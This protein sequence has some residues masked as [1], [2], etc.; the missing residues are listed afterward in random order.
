MRSLA[1][2]AIC[3]LGCA[4]GDYAH[5]CR[6]QPLAPGY[7]AAEVAALQRVGASMTA[8]GVF[9]CSATWSAGSPRAA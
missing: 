2:L 6:A 5:L 7:A 8:T 9:A 4:R 1:A 3:S